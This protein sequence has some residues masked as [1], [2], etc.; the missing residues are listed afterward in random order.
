[1]DEND[2]KLN[3]K[4]NLKTLRT[5]M[6]DMADTVRSNDISVI[7]VAL[8]EQN[9]HEREDLYRKVEGSS[10]KKAFWIIGGIILIGA[11]IYGSY[12]IFKQKA[13]N[14]APQPMQ[15]IESIISYD[16]I[17]NVDL[18]G[19]ENLNDK[20]I[21]IK[22]EIIKSN[23]N[24]LIKYI[25]I[26]KETMGVKEKVLVSKLFSLM[27]TTA[28]SSLVRSLSDSYMMGVYIKNPSAS[29]E[30]DDGKPNLFMILETNDYDF[31][32]AGMLEWEKTIAG[33][34]FNLFEFKTNDNKTELGKKQFKDIIIDN[35]DARVLYSEDNK[36]LLYYIFT[37]KSKIII[38][39]SQDAIRE[40]LG[41]LI[42]KNIKPL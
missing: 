27:E 24:G 39:D 26:T 19:A 9:K 36:P 42:I 40:I 28:P 5:Y 32:Y 38:T 18:T 31:S 3:S 41:R 10:S 21:S 35:K 2:K 37:N 16:E 15:K 30:T 33:D 29:I 20:L 12:F 25:P 8:A 22:K 1:M 13:K 34:M 14:D 17:T 7:K 4:T 11:A 6:S 23:K